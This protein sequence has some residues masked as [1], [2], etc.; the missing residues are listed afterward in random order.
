VSIASAG[1]RDRTEFGQYVMRMRRIAA[2]AVV[3]DLG[4]VLPRCRRRSIINR[5]GSGMPGGYA[6][7]AEDPAA[8]AREAREQTGWR[9][10]DPARAGIDVPAHDRKC[11]LTPGS[12]C[13]TPDKK[14]G[15]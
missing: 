11:R 8:A 2:I 15:L 6:G 13:C 10:P 7:Q 1:L 14:R 4:Q 9:L 3:N 12:L 5:W